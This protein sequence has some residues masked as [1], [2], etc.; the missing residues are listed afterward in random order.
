ML[1]LRCYRIRGARYRVTH[2]PLQPKRLGRYHASV[3][4]EYLGSHNLL[5]YV[6]HAVSL[7]YYFESPN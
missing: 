7:I 6:S 3:F 4:Q 1:W 2:A 5:I